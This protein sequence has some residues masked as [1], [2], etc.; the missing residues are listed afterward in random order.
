[1]KWHLLSYKQ[2]I[3]LL[4]ASALVILILCYQYGF[5]NTWNVYADYKENKIKT[6]QLED[7]VNLMPLLKNE[8]KKI[9]DLIK[10]NLLDTLTDAKETLAFITT[11]CKI[12]N[13][14]LTEYQPVQIAGNDNFNIAT[15]QISVEGNYSGLLKLVYELEN[16]QIYGRLCSVIFKSAEDPT[17]GKI[18]L[19]CTFYLQNLMKK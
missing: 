14:K 13:L 7:Y 19:S 17:S 10:N 5:K 15:R 16:H 4:V 11:F 8:E 9:N 3:K 12:N 6:E 2:K 1:M 18:S